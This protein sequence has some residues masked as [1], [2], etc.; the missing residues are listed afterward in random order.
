[1][2]KAVAVI[3]ILLAIGAGLYFFS[4]S[5]S[6]QTLPSLPQSEDS[7]EEPSRQGIEYQS[8]NY[9]AYNK[10]EFESA[11]LAGKVVMLYFTANWCPICKEQEPVNKEALTELSSDSEIIAFRVHI[12]DSEETAE[13]KALA[14]EYGVRY[15]HTAVLI[16]SGGGVD[17]TIVGPISKQSLKEKLLAAKK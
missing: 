17:Q 15:Q 10:Q 4:S 16:D 9:R 1:M 8:E 2:K 6:S 11:L 5:R 3:A 13:T 7:S 14:E 12:L